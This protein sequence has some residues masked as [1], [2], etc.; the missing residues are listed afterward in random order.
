MNRI[1][2]GFFGLVLIFV[3]SDI[4]FAQGIGEYGR[5]VGG[6][7]QGSRG[8][9]SRTS[10]VGVKKGKGVVEGVGGVESGSA[11]PG[12]LVVS[13]K[14]ATLYPR[15]DDETDQI[16]KLSQGELLVPIMH[17]T[18]APSDWYL[19]KTQKGTVGWIKSADV[20]KPEAKKR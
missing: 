18:G 6:V 12:H 1:V 11:L 20:Q 3:V 8:V 15:Q 13:A 17:S 19:V 14:G 2:S 9:G 10:G 5:V 4:A 7:T 16:E